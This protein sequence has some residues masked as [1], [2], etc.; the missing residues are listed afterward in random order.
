MS[1]STVPS[2]T[3]TDEIATLDVPVLPGNIEE[4]FNNICDRLADL[5][6]KETDIPKDDILKCKPQ[7]MS[8]NSGSTKKG[9]KKQKLNID[10]WRSASSVSEIKTL[11][12]VELKDILSSE[13]LRTSGNKDTMAM[14][15]WGILH[16][17]EAPDDM[18][19][20]TRSNKKTTNNSHMLVEDTP[21]KKS[22]SDEEDITNLIQNSVQITI[23]DD[24]NYRYV[25]SKM[26]L[27]K[28]DDDEDME[29]V[30]VLNTDLK[31]FNE[32]DAPQI[33]VDLFS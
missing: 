23:N 16:P 6:S 31:S 20:K 11:K 19:K 25:K 33:L 22:L 10:D 3:K 8:I 2:I 27:F 26:W 32:V 21:E 30:G 24:S 14:R 12:G 17:E 15:V 29:W 18:H 7:N 5:V 13:G 4:Q 28:L 1:T 9:T